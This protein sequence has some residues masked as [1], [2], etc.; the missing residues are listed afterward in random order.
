MTEQTEGS[1]KLF[2][3]RLFRYFRLFRILFFFAFV[4]I[5]N[6]TQDQ[7]RTPGQTAR[8]AWAG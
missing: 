6:E 4:K 3:F 7:Q 5:Q 8:D 2:L 1:I